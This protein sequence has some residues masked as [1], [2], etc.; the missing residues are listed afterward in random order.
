M[1]HAP[2]PQLYGSWF[3]DSSTPRAGGFRASIPLLCVT[4][5]TQSMTTSFDTK[6]VASSTLP[7]FDKE[8]PLASTVK[9][10][11]E[12]SESLL[13]AD[14][15]ALVDGR[16]PRTLLQYRSSA[17]PSSLVAGSRQKALAWGF[18][19]YPARKR[20]FAILRLAGP[21]QVRRVSESQPPRAQVS[22][23]GLRAG[24]NRLR[25]HTPGCS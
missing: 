17:V 16:T 6:A 21:P 15:R 22:K 20:A 24:G 25:I 1:T 13:P 23:P 2:A 8:R 18:R 10:W 11:I 5:C 19:P 9:E 4:A 14:Q 12:Q 7:L 3:T